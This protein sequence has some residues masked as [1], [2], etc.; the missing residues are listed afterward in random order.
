[1]VIVYISAEKRNIKKGR[2]KSRS[3]SKVVRK[4]FKCHKEKHFKKNC[5]ER[6]KK[7]T[8]KNVQNEDSSVAI[9][10][11]YET[12]GALPVSNSDSNEV[13]VLD[14]CCTFHMTPNR[15]WLFE[16]IQPVNMVM[17]CLEITNHVKSWGQG[18][19]KIRLHFG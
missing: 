2:G 6:N 17:C 14:S 9:D 1:M 16:Y 8:N 11:E 10:D 18:S 4:C 19:V 15:N 5:P 13:W 7:D 3:K 12:A